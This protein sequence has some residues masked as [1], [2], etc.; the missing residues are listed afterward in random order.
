[1]NMV[2]GVCGFGSSGSSAVTDY[3]KEF[4]STS[5]LDDVEFTLPFIPDGLKDLDYHLNECIAKYYSSDVALT[6]FKMCVDYLATELDGYTGGKFKKLSYQ[7][8]DSILQYKRI[9]YGSSDYIIFNGF[10]HRYL[11]LSI[12]KGRIIPFIEKITKRSIVMWPMREMMFSIKPDNFYTYTQQ[13]IKQIL[14]AM[15]ADMT[16][17]VILNQP[18]PGNDPVSYFKFFDKAKAIVVDR[19]PRDTYAFA[20]K[21]LKNAGRYIPTDSVEQFVHYYKNMREGM[22]Y[23]TNK[24]KVLL[25]KFEDLVYNYEDTSRQ[26]D[27]F[28]GIKKEERIKTLFVPKHS[29]NNTQVFRRYPELSKDIEFIERELNKYLFDFGKYKEFTPQGQMFFGRSSLNK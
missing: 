8:I 22:P 24:E 7:Y 25:I 18:F 27:E 26:I 21:F 20:K 23:Q 9:G 12:M 19:D 3:L 1:M 6:R 14:I 10:F 4:S 5:V 11:G 29:I 16:K 2:I 17:P 13:Y 15:G 28:C